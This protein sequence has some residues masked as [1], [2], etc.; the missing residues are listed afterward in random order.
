MKAR[1]PAYAALAVVL[2]LLWVFLATRGPTHV[3]VAAVYGYPPS[4]YAKETFYLI[5]PFDLATHRQIR[6]EVAGVQDLGGAPVRFRVSGGQPLLLAVEG[7]TR[8]L[9]LK[10]HSPI[11]ESVVDV[12]KPPDSPVRSQV[13]TDGFLYPR[14]YACA[15]LRAL[16]V[17]RDG[18]GPLGEQGQVLGWLSL[19]RSGFAVWVGAGQ[20]SEQYQYPVAADGVF[21]FSFK[22]KL[23]WNRLRVRVQARDGAAARSVCERLLSLPAAPKKVRFT[24]LAIL[25]DHTRGQSVLVAKASVSSSLGSTRLFALLVAWGPDGWALERA[26]VPDVSGR[27][28]QLRFPLSRDGIYQLRLSASPLDGDDRTH[29]DLVVALDPARLQHSPLLSCID[30]WMHGAPASLLQPMAR[31]CAWAQ[32]IV[33]TLLVNTSQ[34]SSSQLERSH[35]LRDVVLLSAI[36]ALLM[37]LTIATAWAGVREFRSSAQALATEWGVHDGAPRYYWHAAILVVLVGATVAVLVFLL[38]YL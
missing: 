7:G 26:T 19:G 8:P 23:L 2:L 18:M 4:A 12:P 9:R 15:D 11:G 29:D 20:G 36:V 30:T 22:Q 34:E 28:L 14:S 38:T 33:P 17:A 31:A 3:L 37:S 13:R 32:R 25:P 1:W 27:G 6:A 10:L 21:S 16:L 35:R 24:G 5:D